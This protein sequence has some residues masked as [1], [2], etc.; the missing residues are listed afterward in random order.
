[1]GKVNQNGKNTIMF[2]VHNTRGGKPIKTSDNNVK[3]GFL[4]NHLSREGW[5][6]ATDEEMKA[7]FPEYK[8]TKKEEKKLTKPSIEAKKE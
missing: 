5:R 7:F 8:P 6:K 2:I 4:L 1:M 3:N